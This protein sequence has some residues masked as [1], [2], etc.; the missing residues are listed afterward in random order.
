MINLELLK[1]LVKEALAKETAETLDE[2][3]S[4]YPDYVPL[5]ERSVE[6]FTGKSTAKTL[7]AVRGSF[8]PEKQVHAQEYES[9]EHGMLLSSQEYNMNMAA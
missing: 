9:G 8:A 6:A 3:L 2:F 4:E 5:S 7:Q 1:T